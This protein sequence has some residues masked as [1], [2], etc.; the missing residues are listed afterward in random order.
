MRRKRRLGPRMRIMVSAAIAAAALFTAV[1]H[2]FGSVATALAFA[3]G[4]A[5]AAVTIYE[6]VPRKWTIVREDIP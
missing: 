3:I 4:A 6:L 5:A 1:D 2:P